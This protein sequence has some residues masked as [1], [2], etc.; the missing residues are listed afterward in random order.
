MTWSIPALVGSLAFDAVAGKPERTN[1]VPRLLAWSAVLMGLGYGISC[2]AGS[3]PP[4]P[5]VQPAPSSPVT[6][7]TMS[8]RTGSVSYQIFAAGFSLAVYALF[9]VLCDQ[10]GL[11]IGL[12]RTFGQNALAAYIVHPM[13]AAAVKPYA[14]N[15]AP[16]WYVAAGFL[17]Y[18]GVCYLLIRH[19]EKHGIF[20][21]L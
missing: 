17:I 1:P 4:P 21:R 19:L 20:L 3:I 5:F 8:Q 16:L 18:F 10:G 11:G 7:W 12:F 9:V 6:L 15:D 13:V 2:L 14:P